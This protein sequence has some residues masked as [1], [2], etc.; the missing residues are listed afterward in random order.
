MGKLVIRGF[1]VRNEIVDAPPSKAFTLR[2]LLAS[3]LSRTWVNL[4]RLNWGDD[5]WSM[6]RG[7]KPITEIEIKGDLVRVRRGLSPERFR[8]IDVGESGFTLRTLTGVYAGIDGVTI[9]MPRGSLVN[10][11]MDELISALKAINAKIDKSGSVIRIVG[12]K[13]VGGYVSIN[14]SV[15][16]QFISSLLYLA[17]LTE[18]G[19]EVSIR[20]PIKSRPYIDATISVLR[21][22]GIS[23]EVEDNSIY[24]G[25]AAGV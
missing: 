11:P 25:G 3:A 10:R 14:G 1:K 4:R 2:Y 5:T 19:I 18:S 23:V 15:S 7:V 24:I 16:S 12:G 8:I 21:D 9:L 20:P 6:I 13:L 17:P 22:F